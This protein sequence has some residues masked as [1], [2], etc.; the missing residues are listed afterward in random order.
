MT[1]RPA[2]PPTLWNDVAALTTKDGK[3]L[4]TFIIGKELNVVCHN[5]Q[6]GGRIGNFPDI[7][8]QIAK[9]SYRVTLPKFRGC[10]VSKAADTSSPPGMQVLSSTS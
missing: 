3:L 9:R 7:A 10:V 6:Y 8:Q 5:Y 2:L 1:P 4:P